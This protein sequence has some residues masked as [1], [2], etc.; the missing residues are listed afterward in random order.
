MEVAEWI[1]LANFFHGFGIHKQIGGSNHK[2]TVKET[3]IK[4]L[5]I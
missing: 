3:V 1:E 4:V 2:I 5:R